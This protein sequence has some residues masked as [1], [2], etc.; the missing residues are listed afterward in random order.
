MKCLSNMRISQKDT[1]LKAIET[2]GCTIEWRDE[3]DEHMDNYSDRASFGSIW[4]DA[5]DLSEFWRAY[6]KLQKAPASQ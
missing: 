3:P 4:S 1:I 2:S 5:P 6:H